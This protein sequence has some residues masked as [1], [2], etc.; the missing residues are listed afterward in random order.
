MSGDRL[1][2]RLLDRFPDPYA[3]GR[4]EEF[5]PHYVRLH[6]RRET[7]ELHALGTVACGVCVV[8]G[9]ALHRPLMFL[10]GVAIDHVIAQ[11]SHRV[12]QR[13]ATKPWRHPLWHVRAELRMFRL[14][15]TGKMAE[16]TQRYI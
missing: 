11:A 4:F 15:L 13:N 9:L 1:R 8:L 3:S 14:V 12:Y 16:E 6:S 10:V 5:W 2:E 7:Q